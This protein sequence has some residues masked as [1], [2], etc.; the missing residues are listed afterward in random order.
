MTGWT[1]DHASVTEWRVRD[2]LV[3]GVASDLL[4][5]MAGAGARD[6]TAV[7]CS[8][9]PF[10]ILYCQK[11]TLFRPKANF[12]F[13]GMASFCFLHKFHHDLWRKIRVPNGT[14]MIDST[15]CSFAVVAGFGVAWLSQYY[16]ISLSSDLEPAHVTEL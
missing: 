4:S 14:S 8:A 2:V 1:R 7:L 16:L 11:I 6:P 13:P 12:G 3:E 15:K 9:R 5:L 10:F